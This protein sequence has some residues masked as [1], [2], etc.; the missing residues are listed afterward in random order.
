MDV[1]KIGTKRSVLVGRRGDD[2]GAI[3]KHTRYAVE[4]PWEDLMIYPI[5]HTDVLVLV[6]ERVSQAQQDVTIGAP[7]EGGID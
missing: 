2:M 4:L 3:V 7:R 5:L 1:T 6:E